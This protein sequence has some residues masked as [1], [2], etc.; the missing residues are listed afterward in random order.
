MTP[1]LLAIILTHTAGLCCDVSL[2]CAVM[3]PCAVLCALQKSASGSP[4]VI[5][6]PIAQAPV[7]DWK[8][9]V[10][11]NTGK[12]IWT[13]QQ[14]ND[15]LALHACTHVCGTARMHDGNLSCC[16][17]PLPCVLPPVPYLHCS[18]DQRAQHQHKRVYGHCSAGRLVWCNK[19]ALQFGPRRQQ[20]TSQRWHAGSLQRR[21]QRPGQPPVCKRWRPLLGQ[22]CFKSMAADKPRLA[23]LGVCHYRLFT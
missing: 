18:G 14:H 3:P 15:G 21:P 7:Q 8:C 9:Y 16:A 23:A 1:A 19:A 5:T 10:A 22:F 12:L 2:R 17:L 11:Y 4:W 13:M 6:G 20:R